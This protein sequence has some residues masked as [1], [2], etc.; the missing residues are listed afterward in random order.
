MANA[1]DAPSIRLEPESGWDHI[2]AGGLAVA[3]QQA[4]LL[5]RVATQRGQGPSRLDR[6]FLL[7]EHPFGRFE[8]WLGET[9]LV[10]YL[11]ATTP[12]VPREIRHR[13]QDVAVS[14]SS[15]V[16][17]R[18]YRRVWLRLP[19]SS[20]TSVGAAQ[21]LL[22][23]LG[24]GDPDATKDLK[25]AAAMTEAQWTERAA[26]HAL[27]SS[28]FWAHVE[29]KHGSHGTADWPET[30]PHPIYL[31]RSD[32]YALT[33]DI[34]FGTDFGGQALQHSS[35]VADILQVSAPWL[36]LIGDLDCLGEVIASLFMLGLTP[37][38]GLDAAYRRSLGAQIERMA[39]QPNGRSR[40]RLPFLP[41]PVPIPTPVIDY[42]PIYVATIAALARLRKRSRPQPKCQAPDEAAHSV[43]VRLAEQQLQ[44]YPALP[45]LPRRA[46][47]DLLPSAA[48]LD[49]L[50][51]VAARQYRPDWIEELLELRSSYRMPPSWTT[52]EADAFARLQGAEQAWTVHAL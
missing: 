43:L 45:T 12:A 46:L 25:A 42:H 38:E 5:R 16:A 33:H 31:L 35:N 1:G 51:V 29:P 14:L 41:P 20:V 36:C 11:T 9:I 30:L 7:V 50:L 22:H 15:L 44:M 48:L 10:A 21:A 3:V 18:A 40:R 32:I 37:L 23:D 2:L 6:P 26:R 27:E 13:G 34:W 47:L 39:S 24:V 17:H 49:G 52:H 8:K 4:H 28:W 19:Y